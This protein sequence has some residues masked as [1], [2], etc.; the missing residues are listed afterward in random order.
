[1]SGNGG[2]E[3]LGAGGIQLRQTAGSAVRIELRCQ[4]IDQNHGWMAKYRCEV[5]Y[6]RHGD[7]SDEPLGFTTRQDMLQGTAID[8]E[9]QIRPMRSRLSIASQPIA[10]Q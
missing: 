6:L 10:G 7:G 9:S 2:Q 1:M 8:G 5:P 3:D 4:I